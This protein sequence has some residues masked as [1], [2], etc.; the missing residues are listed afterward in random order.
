MEEGL[1]SIYENLRLDWY[2]VVPVAKHR[3]QLL[4]PHVLAESRDKAPNAPNVGCFIS[5]IMTH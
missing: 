5:A 4:L 2:V 3:S 1:F